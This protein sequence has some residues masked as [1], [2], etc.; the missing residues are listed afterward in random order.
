MHF[1]FINLYLCKPYFNNTK[2]KFGLKKG[3]KALVKTPVMGQK[4]NHWRHTDYKVNGE[5]FW[6]NKTGYT[7][8]K[9]CYPLGKRLIY[10]GLLYSERSC[11][12]EGGPLTHPTHTT[13]PHRRC[14]QTH[15]S[16]PSLSAVAPYG[17]VLFILEFP[18]DIWEGWHM[19]GVGFNK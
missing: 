10:F 19:R 16:P 4:I 15:N 12:V 7:L 11:E 18:G 9:S 13:A 2:I 6:K 1:W 14:A 17:Q 5:N 8:Q 3:V